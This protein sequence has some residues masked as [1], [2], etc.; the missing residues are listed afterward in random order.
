[1][2]DKIITVSMNPAI[3]ATLWL[4]GLD[5]NEPNQVL[6]EKTYAGGKG[7][8]ISRV[9]ASYGMPSV[10]TGICGEENFPYF[11]RLLE[12]DGVNHDFIVENGSTR[13]NLSVTLPDGKM[14]KIN[15]Q[16]T[17][18]DFDT[19]SRLREKILA[20]CQGHERVLVAFAGSIPP[21]LSADAYKAF[22]HQVK[23]ENVEIALD[24]TVFGLED[25]K[26][27]K[28]FVIKP[29]LSEFRKICG[30]PLRTEQVTV[31][32]CRTL[33][34]S[35]R[36]VMISLGGKGLL[37][38]TGDQAIRVIPPVVQVKSTVAAGDTTLATFLYALCQ[39]KDDTAAA[40]YAAA[41]G[42]ASVTLDGTAI[43]TSDAV[44]KMI[45]QMT[46]KML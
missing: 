35:V 2:F 11:K 4:S 8:N 21:N 25:L 46:V 44:E 28:P 13:E 38:C 36:Y 20:E 12:S 23:R 40:A 30:N 19:M 17:P 5:F 29:N 7:V 24:T 34:S 42:T 22:I 41:A 6:K 9:L 3:D 1:M 10:A 43:V 33:T 26:E 37:C 15:R 18:V 32:Y 27:I 39:G 45:P 31:K 14:L 16:G